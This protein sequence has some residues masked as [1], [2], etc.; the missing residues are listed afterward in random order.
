M[1]DRLSV[2]FTAVFH[3]KEKR[4]KCTLNPLLNRPDI[5]AF[6][7]PDLEGIDFEGTVLLSPGGDPLTRENS[8]S[9]LLVVDS[10]W[11]YAGSIVSKIPCPRRSIR[12]FVTA[13]P[14]TSKLFRDP[15]GGLAS[16]EALFAAALI[17]GIYDDTLLEHYRWKQD[18]L[19]MNK[20]L[21]ENLRMKENP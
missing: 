13:Y 8:G 11:R 7:F 20:R 15:P 18:F 9:H 10:T 4:H 19:K 12:G 17:L 16:A 3:P 5:E 14:R 21:I 6:Q 1:E 2:K